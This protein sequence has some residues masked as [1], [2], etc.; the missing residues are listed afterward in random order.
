MG[1]GH[2]YSNNLYHVIYSVKNKMGLIDDYWQKEIH[3]YTCGII[4]AEDCKVV[5]I[6]GVKDHVHILVKIK[7]SIAVSD[8]LR[9]VKANSSKWVK[10]KYSPVNGFQWQTG[11]S[12]FTVSESIA[13][14][15]SS[16]ILNQESHHKKVSF[17]EEL[18]LFYKMNKIEFDH[19]YLEEF[20]SP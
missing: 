8:L 6:G 18:I 4:H 10:E 9:K 16:Y 11:Y 3:S 17:R 15:V 13:A 7:P 2:T 1:Y 19:M 5:T 14:K 20:L 12:C